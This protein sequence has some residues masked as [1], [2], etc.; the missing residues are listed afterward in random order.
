MRPLHLL[1]ALLVAAIWGF[2]FVVIR[3][4]LDELPPILFTA[5]R[6]A[7]AALPLPLL[8]LKP[9]V[10]W[11]Y[12]LGIGMFLGALQFG[13]LFVGMEMG[14]PAG[15]ASIVVQSQA[16]FTVALSA[17]VLGERPAARQY[18]GMALAAAGVLSIAATLPGGGTVLGMAIVLTGSF[19][20][21]VANL[22]MKKAQAPDMLRLMVWT[23][24]V[25]PLPLLALSL[26]MEGPGEI[27]SSL[28][29]LSGRGVLVILYNAAGATIVGYGLWAWLLRHYSA[30][31]V[32][33]FSLLVPV[34]GM[35]SAALFL[36]ET[37]T[38]V[39]LAACGLILAGLALT[40]LPAR[41]RPA[42]LEVPA[43][44]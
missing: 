43:G 44:E 31:L 8:G 37:F 13:C 36:G 12:L 15:L 42:P 33:P 1:L 4:G 34:F 9:P 18:L 25:P 40:V 16:L 30:S 23:S 21:A 27:A 38:P 17:L 5:L 35:S 32:A 14:M 28:A 29:G 39:K 11:R 7:V 6:F 3:W 10:A 26:A 19:C 22:I 41:R 20:W 2:N 24:L